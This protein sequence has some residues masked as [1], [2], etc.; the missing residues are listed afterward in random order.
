MPR[1]A[2]SSPKPAFA[3]REVS[4][5]EKVSGRYLTMETKN[6]TGQTP[7]ASVAAVAAGGGIERNL[8][9]DMPKQ[10]QYKMPRR[11]A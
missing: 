9:F 2:S 6:L 1:D 7:C 3:A 10:W 5:L 8:M 11:R 4:P